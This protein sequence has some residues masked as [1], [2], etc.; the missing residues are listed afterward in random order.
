MDENKAKAS[1][2][3]ERLKAQ[4][5]ARQKTS[6]AQREGTAKAPAG[7]VLPSQ[8]QAALVGAFG[9]DAVAGLTAYDVAVKMGRAA[10]LKPI[11]KDQ[12]NAVDAFRNSAEL[13]ESFKRS[14]ELVEA[15]RKSAE[16]T[17]SFKRSAELVEALRGYA[18]LGETLQRLAGQASPLAPPQ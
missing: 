17:E 4:D 11:F 16:L 14:A 6:Q 18:E 2:F 12:S 8:S 9:N 3:I 5:E 13:T 15:F 10:E 1:E 7:A